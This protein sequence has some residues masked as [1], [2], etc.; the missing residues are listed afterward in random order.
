MTVVSDFSKVDGIAKVLWC[1]KTVTPLCIKSGTTSAWHQ[2]LERKTR[3]VAAHFDFFDK[4]AD[5]S[6]SDFYYD[7]SIENDTLSLQYRIPPSSIRGPLRDYTIRKLV[8]REFWTAFLMDE[9]EEENLQ[10][11]GE[12]AGHGYNAFLKDAL[13]CSGWRIVQG[14]FGLTV[15]S[16]DKALAGETVAGRLRCMVGD[17]EELPENEFKGGL[18]SGDFDE[19]FAAGPTN[20][21]MNISTRN[22]IDRITHA[23]KMGGLHSFMELA[24][25]NIF[26][27]TF[28]IIN[29]TPED[30][31]LV[32]FWEQGIRDGLIRFGGL[33]AA[34]RGRV[35]LEKGSNIILFLRSGNGF[36]GLVTSKSH[37]E[38]KLAGIFAEYTFPDWRKAMTGYLKKLELAYQSEVKDE[39]QK[40][41]HQGEAP[42]DTNQLNT[43]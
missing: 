26:E 1:L 25:G 41:R 6:V 19:R 37:S 35:S 23:G 3:E 30:L 7:T 4:S 12:E 9:V 28:Q 13:Q 20:G 34:G 17:L 39:V 38:D 18:I 29:P 11:D 5:Q 15:G 42:K 14:L 21:R 16:D 43:K 40:M 2:G 32:A 10:H 8:P 33:K 27:A 36:E 31:G 24:H 22:P